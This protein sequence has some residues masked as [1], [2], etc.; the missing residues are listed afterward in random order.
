MTALSRLLTKVAKRVLSNNPTNEQMLETADRVA[1]WRN[2]DYISDAQVDEIAAAMPEEPVEAEE[3]EPEAE[4][5]PAEESEELALD[6]A[7][8]TKHD[9]F[10]WA[11]ARGVTVYESWTKAEMIDAIEAAL[12]DQS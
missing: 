1:L 8:M 10:E 7:S 4:H 12:A 5:A 2:A 3:P 11:E 9:L 6:F